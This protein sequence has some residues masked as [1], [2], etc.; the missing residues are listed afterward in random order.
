M[1][2]RSVSQRWHSP[3]LVLVSCML[4]LRT[5]DATTIP[6]SERLFALGDT[7]KAIGKLT[8]KR[9]EKAVYPVGFY[10]T[11]A[12]NI[13]GICKSLLNSF[14]GKVPDEIDTLLTFKGVGRKT[15]NLVLAQGFGK[16]AICVDTHVHR[17]VNRLGVI[18]SD[19]PTQ[20]EY[21]LREVLPQNFWIEINDIF[22]IFGRTLC[23]PI[24]PICSACGIRGLCKRIGV[25]KSR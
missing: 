10:K 7:P 1:L 24:S 19:N 5:K 12:R 6:A 14:D 20:S 11:K 16:P 2:F 22:V 25:N 21:A 18:K 17:I 9:I 4:S 8:V 15:A 23:K 3:F 13:K